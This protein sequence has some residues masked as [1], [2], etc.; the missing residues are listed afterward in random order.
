VERDGR[1][2]GGRQRISGL[3]MRS[4]RTLSAGEIERQPGSANGAIDLQN[5]VLR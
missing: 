3:P 4:K 1:S 2:R 5:A